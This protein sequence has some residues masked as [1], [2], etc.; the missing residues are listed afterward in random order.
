MHCPRHLKKHGMDSRVATV[1]SLFD[2][3]QTQ[4]DLAKA[5]ES[6]EPY[7]SDKYTYTGYS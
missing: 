6:I 2:T 4:L 7:R 3:F 5:S 1:S